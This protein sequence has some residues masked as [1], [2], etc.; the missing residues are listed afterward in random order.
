MRASDLTPLAIQL[1]PRRRGYTL[2]SLDTWLN[3][4]HP[5]PPETSERLMD[6]IVKPFNR[7]LKE[8]TFAEVG[9]ANK[10][11]AKLTEELKRRG[12]RL[13]GVA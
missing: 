2:N 5:K 13:H 4:R 3:E 11:Y 10:H 7:P 8:L 1:S 6:M 9:K 12:Q